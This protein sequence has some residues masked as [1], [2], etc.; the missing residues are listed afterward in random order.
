[1]DSHDPGSHDLGPSRSG[2]S[3]RTVTESPEP[4]SFYDRNYELNP[5]T[6]AWLHDYHHKFDQVTITWLRDC[7]KKYPFGSQR[8]FAG[9]PVELFCNCLEPDDGSEMI[10]CSNGKR[11]CAREWYH[12]RCL[13]LTEMPAESD[14]WFCQRCIEQKVGRLAHPGLRKKRSRS[15]SQIESTPPRIKAPKNGSSK[16][17]GGYN[18][19]V[20]DT[21][22]QGRIPSTQVQGKGL[23]FPV[24]P[25]HDST[26]RGYLWDPAEEDALIGVIGAFI[27]DWLGSHGSTVETGLGGDATEGFSAV[28]GSSEGSLEWIGI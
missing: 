11:F 28:M 21:A 13:D 4:S 15:P 16:T 8:S 12:T 22:T 27:T 7:E 2:F 3:S 17:F 25:G 10:Q 18:D 6:E 19:A 20:P 26:G 23:R 9:D 14:L 24:D 5:E 1:M